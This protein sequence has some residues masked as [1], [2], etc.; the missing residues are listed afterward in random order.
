MPLGNLPA[1]ASRMWEEVYASSQERGLSKGA[2][3]GQAWCAVKRHYYKKG[4]RWLKRKKSLR[5][6]Q[7]PPGCTPSS[8][9]RPNP[10]CG[11]YEPDSWEF[12]G[13]TDDTT[14]LTIEE[15]FLAYPDLAGQIVDDCARRQGCTPDKIRVRLANPD[16]E[17]AA[18]D[19]LVDEFFNGFARGI[20]AVALAN[21]SEESIRSIKRRVLR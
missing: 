12:G 16:F 14:G 5:P 3:A 21:P 6:D 7:Q 20:E 18:D 11:P 13:R 17:S 9:Y 8:A 10:D 4:G 19:A 15:A 1:K 2:S